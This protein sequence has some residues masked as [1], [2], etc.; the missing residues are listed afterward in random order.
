[1]I[2]SGFMLM[3]NDKSKLYFIHWGHPTVFP[4]TLYAHPAM[5]KDKQMKTIVSVVNDI[6]YQLFFFKFVF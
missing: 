3:R 5:E 1:M 4:I 6:S 2:L